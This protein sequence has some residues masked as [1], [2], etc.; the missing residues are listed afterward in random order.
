MQ[1]FKKVSLQETQPFFMLREIEMVSRKGSGCS[2]QRE[3]ILVMAEQEVGFINRCYLGSA[4]E[5]GNAAAQ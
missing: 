5:A 4:L 2:E 3:D 1:F